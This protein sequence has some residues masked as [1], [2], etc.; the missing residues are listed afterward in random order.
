MKV[1]ILRDTPR[2]IEFYLKNLQ[3]N[4]GLGIKSTQNKNE[5]FYENLIRL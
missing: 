3:L 2:T 5:K 4:T 1:L